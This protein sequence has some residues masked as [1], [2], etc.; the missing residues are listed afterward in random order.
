MNLNLL[1]GKANPFGS[2]KSAGKAVRRVKATLPRSPR[3]TTHA[4]KTPPPE[5][6]LNDVF[7]WETRGRNTLSPITAHC[8]I[9]FYESKGSHE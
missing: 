7:N 6:C 1:L 9:A 8:V 5:F 3:K 4:I 2:A